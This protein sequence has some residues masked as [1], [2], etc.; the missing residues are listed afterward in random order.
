MNRHPL[1][2][3]PLEVAPDSPVGGKAKAL[4]SLAQA[5]LPI[6]GWFVLLPAAFDLSLGNAEQRL[7]SGAGYESGQA[8]ANLLAGLSLSPEVANEVLAAYKAL[9]PDGA[10]V[11]VR[12]SAADEDSAALSF[13]GQL[14]SYLFVTPD[15]L[16]QRV[17]DVW[18]SG[19]SER[20]IAYRREAGLAPLPG[21][22]A[23]IVQ[24]VIS[25]AASGVA[26]SGDPVS[27]RRRTTVVAGVLGLGEALVSGE[28]DSDTWHVDLDGRIRERRIA[29]KQI[30]A[31]RDPNN[32]GG[33]IRQP[34][35]AEQADR[36]V[37][38]DAQV[39]A[40][41]R[42]ARDAAKHFGLPQDI[43]WTISE[44][45][46]ELYLLQS[47]PITTLTDKP[48]P[49]DQLRLWDNTNIIESYSGVT[50]PFTFS[51][52][53]RC[54]EEV[55]RGFCR[56]MRVPDQ[57]IEA[58]GE[59]FACLLG[60]LNGRVYYNMLNG[61]R[62]LTLLPGYKLNRRFTEEML[63]FRETL[64]PEIEAEMEAAAVGAKGRDLLA[65]TRPIWGMLLS[66]VRIE[67][68]IE[69]FY[70]RLH[71][72]L[73][74]DPQS[75][76]D[77]SPDDLVKL[78]RHLE[79]ELLHRW[80]APTIND[81]FAAVFHG[82]LRRLTSRWLADESGSLHND[83]LCG[84]RKLVSMEIAEL[85]QRMARLTAAEPELLG[86][87]E[88]GS[89]VAIEVALDAHPD[90]QALY[91]EYLLRFGDR[92]LDELKLES[93][94]VRDDPLPLFRSVGG[95]ASH[96]RASASEPRNLEQEILENAEAEMRRQLAH[97]PV[98]RTVF[99]WVL[100]QTRR[101]VRCRENLRYERTRAFGM[102]RRI[103]VEMGRRLHALA[104]IEDPRDIFYLTIGEMLAMVDG[105]AVTRDLAALVE[106]RKREFARYEA[107]PAPAERFNTR[108][109][110]YLGDQF[111]KPPPAS[112]MRGGEVLAGIGCCPGIVRGPVQVV[113]D[114]REALIAPGTIV[115]ARRTDPGWVMVFPAAAGLLVERGSM[116]SHSA[117]VAREMGLPTIVSIPGLI[118]SLA[119][120]DLVE[121]DGA[122]G[123]VG[124][125]E[126]GE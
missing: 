92:C 21:A 40:V 26:F 13:A 11:A 122:A 44:G 66:F 71:R 23:V 90:L 15:R 118:G 123:T 27:G 22:P 24:R 61:Y 109:I 30:A 35:A 107:M 60:L 85:V 3:Q 100:E 110:P 81:F 112:P 86:L 125:I 113:E 19:F 96:I 94:T 115:V 34:V 54:Y 14:E 4:A 63:G 106:L 28:S 42:L 5:R 37:L 29:H 93:S 70:E 25:G 89:R 1:I 16:L 83:L 31:R 32:P 84:D 95:Y 65:L 56:I 87:M 18:R 17:V 33:M 75:L 126:A 78:Y 50:S 82:S 120:G 101:R 45:E 52:I 55:Y 46:G 9:C 114:P 116:L 62:I 121:M 99:A 73:P 20:I 38:T 36:P 48:D 41:S 47:R 91:K 108:G 80:D 103:G 124:R 49:D 7:L 74:Q 76:A 79:T 8:V 67:R 39:A 58:H 105:A 102:A 77:A 97:R 59:V 119:D 53:S 69:A 12:S 68:R 98:R 64:P 88:T 72:V 6:P 111:E 51:F 104:L 2:L 43:E 57:V 10:P 117:I